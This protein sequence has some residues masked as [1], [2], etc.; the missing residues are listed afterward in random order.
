LLGAACRLPLPSPSSSSLS[1]NAAATLPTTESTP[2]H[3]RSPPS[4]LP[5]RPLCPLDRPWRHLGPACG[6]DTALRYNAASAAPARAPLFER[7]DNCASA[8]VTAAVMPQSPLRRLALDLRFLG[9][10]QSGNGNGSTLTLTLVPGAYGAVTTTP[11]LPGNL[12]CLCSRSLSFCPQGLT[13]G[14]SAMVGWQSNGCVLW[15]FLG[16]VW[17]CARASM[18]RPVTS[19]VCS[20]Y[21]MRASFIK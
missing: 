7:R 16:G 8:A 9:R 10:R 5:L 17:W 19:Y 2:P 6:V 14:A 11:N 1:S 21:Q 4:P 20:L 15:L 13:G 18:P 3:P 12:R